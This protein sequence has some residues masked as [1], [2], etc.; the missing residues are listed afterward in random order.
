[1]KSLITLAY[2]RK[3]SVNNTKPRQQ[4]KIPTIS[5]K[6]RVDLTWYSQWD[7]QLNLSQ[8]E[9]IDELIRKVVNVTKWKAKVFHLAE[10]EKAEWCALRNWI[11]P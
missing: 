2:E 11:I 10:R 8:K 4:M 3:A 5:F 9:Q 7:Y 1:M 6:S